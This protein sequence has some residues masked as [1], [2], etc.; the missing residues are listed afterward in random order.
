M[1]WDREAATHE[2]DSRLRMEGG[3]PA[4]IKRNSQKKESE[5]QEICS[6][7]ALHQIRK[8]DASS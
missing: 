3:L 4:K 7:H 1:E 5:N 6:N 2:R 8:W